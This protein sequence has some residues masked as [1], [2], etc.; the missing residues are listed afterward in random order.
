MR[1]VER[2]GNAGGAA[3]K[4]LSRAQV[5]GEHRQAGRLAGRHGAPHLGCAPSML[6]RLSLIASL[7]GDILGRCGRQ[8]DRHQSTARQVRRGEGANQADGQHN[9]AGQVQRWN[10]KAL[11]GLSGLIRAPTCALMVQSMLPIASG[12]A[13][14]CPSCPNNHTTTQPNPPAQ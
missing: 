8:A 7:W 4:K 2:V 10:K 11:P 9:T 1:T 3:R 14:L 13:P 12:H 5:C 6:H